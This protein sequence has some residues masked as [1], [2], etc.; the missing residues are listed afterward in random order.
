MNARLSPAYAAPAAS[1][2]DDELEI[3]IYDCERLYRM[4]YERFQLH[5]LPHDR[6][7]A[8][9]HLHNMNQAILA[10]PPAVQVLRHAAFER[11]LAA[12]G[13]YA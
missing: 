6:E 11:L 2:L 9:Q 10:R 7:E 4:A 1:S 13:G 8:V 5:G 12:A 3:H